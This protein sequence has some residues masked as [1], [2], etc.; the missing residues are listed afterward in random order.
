MTDTTL[1]SAVN[2]TDID[3]L[4]DSTLD[5]LCDV[6]EFKPFA[7]GA[8]VCTIKWDYSKKINDKPVIEI[9][10]THVSTEELA[11][12]TAT[13]PT[14]GDNTNVVFMLYKKDGT[15]NEI[16]EGQWKEILKPLAAHFGTTTNRQTMDASQGAQCLVVTGIRTDKKDKDNLKHYTSV[17]S[18]AVL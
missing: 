13:P 16:G 8:H 4:L 3:S 11:D 2:G 18:L 6:P 15:K 14:P 17:N 5:D 9:S 12:P 1:D 7:A 10:I